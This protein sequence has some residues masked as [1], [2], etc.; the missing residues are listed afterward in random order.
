MSWETAVGLLNVAV[1][2][3]TILS[4]IYAAKSLQFARESFARQMNVQIFL[5]YNQRFE[6]VWRTAPAGIGSGNLYG[7]LRQLDPARKESTR[8]WVKRYL[9][10]CSEE[11]LL[12]EQGLI[13]QEVWM[14]WEKEIS[15]ILRSNLFR[16]TWPEVGQEYLSQETFH[17]FVRVVLEQTEPAG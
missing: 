6:A 13:A 12:M 10:L 15:R 16:S 9:N 11:H 7:D 4:L 3:V 8:A 5:A 14:L 17:Q 2:S 1:G